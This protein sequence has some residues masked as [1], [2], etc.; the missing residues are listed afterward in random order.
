MLSFVLL[1][2]GFAS[3]VLAAWLFTQEPGWHDLFR[4][5]AAYALVDGILGFATATLVRS[6]RSEDGPHLLTAMTF[7]DA[8]VR[9][10]AGVVLLLLPGITEVP[11]SVVPLFGAA[12]AVAGVLGVIA[13]IA[14]AAAHIRHGHTLGYE[15]MF[16]PIAAVALVSVGIG[17]LLFTD[18]PATAGK[19][20]VLVGTGGVVLGGSF[21][22][23][24]LGAMVQAHARAGRRG[25]HVSH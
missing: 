14:V 20:R 8:L 24:S 16:D 25:R 17:A 6:I 21:L 2:R 12:G 5:V 13:I 3:L 18:P 19:L 10:A 1:L 15:A 11:M 23:A 4:G 9:L 7:T 22:I